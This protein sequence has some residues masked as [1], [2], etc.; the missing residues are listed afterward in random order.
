MYSFL[1]NLSDEVDKFYTKA[2]LCFSKY[3][4]NFV[5]QD[6]DGTNAQMSPLCN[7]K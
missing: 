3:I 6:N 4:M 5:W 7:D 1:V 2:T